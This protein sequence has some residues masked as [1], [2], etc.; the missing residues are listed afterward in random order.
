MTLLGLT[1]IGTKGL[2]EMI[3]NIIALQAFSTDAF[4]RNLYLLQKLMLH[5]YSA[6]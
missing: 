3:A 2:E 5:F 4:Q 6:Y 1:V